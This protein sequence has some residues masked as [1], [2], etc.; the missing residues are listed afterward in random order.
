MQLSC[1]RKVAA[2]APGI[3]DSRLRHLS[4]YAVPAKV[5]LLCRVT[6]R[7]AAAIRAPLAA[8]CTT[9]TGVRPSFAH[10]QERAAMPLSPGA[11]IAMRALEHETSRS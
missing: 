11:H 9:S 3:K 6:W 10:R 1:L 7:P 2:Y 8:W 5:A 4:A